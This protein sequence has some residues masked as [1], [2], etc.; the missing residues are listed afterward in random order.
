MRGD[1]QE[2]ACM[3]QGWSGG[4]VGASGTQWCLGH[5][6]GAIGRG[7]LNHGMPVTQQIITLSIVVHKKGGVL[8]FDCVVG[9]APRTAVVLEDAVLH[10]TV[11]WRQRLKHSHDDAL[12]GLVQNSCTLDGVDSDF[13]KGRHRARAWGLTRHG[14]GL[15]GSLQCSGVVR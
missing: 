1:K 5:D 8:S 7:V 6:R 3:P 10:R 14:D 11:C 12:R 4:L 2:K 13:G 9:R 15:V